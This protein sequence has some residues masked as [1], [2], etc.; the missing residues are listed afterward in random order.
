MLNSFLSY[1]DKVIFSPFSQFQVER[2]VD[3]GEYKIVTVK[4]VKNID[5][6]K[7]IYQDNIFKQSQSMGEFVTMIEKLDTPFLD[8][9]N[10]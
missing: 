3:A 10:K 4:Y 9:I 5:F 1:K 7:Y 6:L 8:S 2:I